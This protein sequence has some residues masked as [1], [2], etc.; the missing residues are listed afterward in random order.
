MKTTIFSM[1]ENIKKPIINVEN[2]LQFINRQRSN[3]PHI[4]DISGNHAG[5]SFNPIEKL[6]KNINK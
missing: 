4:K 6:I 1:G 5:K 2:Y 3:L